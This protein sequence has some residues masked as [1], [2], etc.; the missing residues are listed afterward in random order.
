ML[1]GKQLGENYKQVPREESNHN[2]VLNNGQITLKSQ[3]T[4]VY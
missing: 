1:R 4:W 2:Q 3:G